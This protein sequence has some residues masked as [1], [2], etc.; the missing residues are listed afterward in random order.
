M[1][2]DRSSSPGHILGWIE[3]TYRDV[4]MI[5]FVNGGMGS[6]QHLIT[7]ELAGCVSVWKFHTFGDKTS[8]EINFLAFAER[9]LNL[10]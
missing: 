6:Y 2:L 3:T 10:Q 9:A 7:V 5:L 8:E 1:C 4:V